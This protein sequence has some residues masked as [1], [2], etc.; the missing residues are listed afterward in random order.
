MLTY[1]RDNGPTRALLV[2]MR[3][4]I[5]KIRQRAAQNAGTQCTCFTGTKVQILTRRMQVLNVFALLIQK[6]KY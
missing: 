3:V 6:Y 2:I 1:A 5:L 4:I